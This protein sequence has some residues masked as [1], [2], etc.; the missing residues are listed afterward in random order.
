MPKQVPVVHGKREKKKL[1]G[2]SAS[3][4][5]KLGGGLGKVAKKKRPKKA[6]RLD[7]CNLI[8]SSGFLSNLHMGAL[9]QNT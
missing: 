6:D 5:G 8:W 1:Q 7:M 9:F 3:Q 4:R 2:G